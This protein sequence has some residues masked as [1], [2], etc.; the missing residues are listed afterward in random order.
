[1]SIVSKKVLGWVIP[2]TVAVLV[3]IGVALGD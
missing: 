1:V 3:A 2:L